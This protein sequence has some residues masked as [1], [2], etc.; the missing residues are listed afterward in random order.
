MVVKAGSR[1]ATRKLACQDL[2]PMV[3]ARLLELQFSIGANQPSGKS[4]M[5]PALVRSLQW[6]KA[7]TKSLQECVR[8]VGNQTKHEDIRK[9]C[10]L[11]KQTKNL[12]GTNRE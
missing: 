12:K 4:W 2:I 7:E 9:G 5:K 3:K 1:K 11:R 8:P 10:E 6:V